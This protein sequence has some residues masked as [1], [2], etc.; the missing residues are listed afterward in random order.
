MYC[1]DQSKCKACG[2][3]G[4]EI[5]WENR[6]C[7]G[8]F[9]Y[10]K[11]DASSHTFTCSDCKGTYTEPHQFDYYADGSCHCGMAK[12]DVIRLP[13]D[14]DGN[15]R[16]TLNDAIAILE[17]TVSNDA[18]A[19]VNGDSKTDINDALRILQ[20]LAGWNVTLQ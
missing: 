20:Y 11:C 13:G 9:E 8:E 10:I 3:T 18:N 7:T 2:V 6:Y 4:F 1:T 14:A 19:D 16:V 15:S 17:G 12:G 5:T